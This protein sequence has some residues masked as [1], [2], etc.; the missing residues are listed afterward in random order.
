MN[1]AYVYGVKELGSNFTKAST[2]MVRKQQ[3]SP[4]RGS[5]LVGE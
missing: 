3:G 2:Y 4:E 5:E 1:D